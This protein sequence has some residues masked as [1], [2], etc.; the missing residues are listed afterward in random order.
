MADGD[1]GAAAGPMDPILE[2]LQQDHAAIASLVNEIDVR[3]AS[4]NWQLRKSRPDVDTIQK[5][6]IRIHKIV[7]ALRHI[8]QLPL[9]S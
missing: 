7:K 6:T 3:S 9:P 5:D 8:M 1:L 4:I 2:E